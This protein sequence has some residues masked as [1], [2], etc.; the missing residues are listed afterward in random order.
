MINLL[1]NKPKNMMVFSVFH[2]PPLHTYTTGSVRNKCKYYK[3]N[4]FHGFK[5]PG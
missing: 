1:K 4:F 3:V 5:G 2:P